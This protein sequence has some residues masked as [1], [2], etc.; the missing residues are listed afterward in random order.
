MLFLVE[1][2]SV[3]IPNGSAPLL[4]DDLQAVIGLAIVDGAFQEL[5][6]A[7][8]RKALAG[9]ELSERDRKAAAG[10]RGAASLAEYAVRLEQRLARAGDGARVAVG[11]PASQRPS[12]A[13][14]AS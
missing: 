4:S 13:Q 1:D 12:R 11:R 8:P 7:S 10:I 14:A 3:A 5:L 6:L 2:I 9:M